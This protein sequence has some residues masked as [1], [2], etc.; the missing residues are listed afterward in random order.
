MPDIWLLRGVRYCTNLATS[1]ELHHRVALHAVLLTL[2]G[3]RYAA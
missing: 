2:G 3:L 1:S